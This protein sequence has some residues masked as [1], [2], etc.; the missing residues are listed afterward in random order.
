MFDIDGSARPTTIQ[1]LKGLVLSKAVVLPGQLERVARFAF[2]RPEDVAL[3][4]IQSIST[5]CKVSPRTVM[6]L[7]YAFGF[8]SFREFKVLFQTHLRGPGSD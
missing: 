3:G 8:D 2:E 6:R 4:T 7:A 1:D 5:S